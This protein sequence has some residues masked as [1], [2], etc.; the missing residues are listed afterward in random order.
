VGPYRVLHQLGAGVLGPVFRAHDTKANALVAIKLFRL[1]A[2]PEQA[3][4]LAAALEALCARLPRH[5][6]IVTAQAAGLDGSAAW[7][8]EDYFA[9]D[10]LDAR[11]KRRSAG[12][13]RAVLPVLSQIAEALDAAAD[14]GVYHG[15]L[16]PRDVLVSTRLE[17]RITG[18]GI[19]QA[20]ETLG[21]AA[22]VRRPY[23]APERASGVAWRR[24][25]DIFSL[26]VL[27]FEMITGRRPVGFGA[28]AAGLVSGVGEGVDADACRHALGR[29][30][31]ERAADRF[32][33]GKEFI[34]ALVATLGEPVD[35]RPRPREE[36]VVAPL[37]VALG[38][39]PAVEPPAAPVSVAG[40][41]A[42]DEPAPPAPTWSS[43]CES[44][45]AAGSTAVPWTGT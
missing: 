12:G 35:L 36:P 26:G 43:A 5:P 1:D 25:A 34:D 45:T 28:S 2:T 40:A 4:D 18:L 37:L 21:L 29:A 39:E 17:V 23:T 16:H 33:H 8:A 31:A 14:A 41:D 7:L 27:A 15:T 42:L 30:L 6:C 3:R 20:L 32:S 22:P 38:E 44:G 13:L 24:Q 9:A 19:A 11:L 10:T